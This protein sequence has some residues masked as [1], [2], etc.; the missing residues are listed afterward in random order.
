MNVPSRVII[1][2]C[3]IFIFTAQVPSAQQS[4][5]ANVQVEAQRLEQ[6]KP[7]EREV[8]AG[9]THAYT[10]ALEAGQ[11][12]GAAVNQRGIDV[13]VRVFAPDGSKIAE[14][15]SPNGTQGD[16]PIALEARTAGTY[17]IEVSPFVQGAQPG[18]YEIRINE[19]LS[20]DAYAKRLAENK[21]K[22]RAV[23]A[24]LKENAIPL[25]TV[26]A[27][28]GF[29][30]LQPLKRIFKDVRFVGLGEETHGTREFFQFKHRMLEFLVKEM[31]FRVFAIEASYAACQNIND[32]VM[33]RTDDGAKA[34]DSQGFWTWN[35]EEVRAMMDWMREYNRGVPANRKVKFVG[36]DIQV[37]DTGKAKLLE[38]LKRV[39]PER[40]VAVEEFFK[41]NLS[42]LNSALATPDEQREA[43]AKLKEL[44][45]K[46]NDLFVFLEIS[47]ANLAAKS[48]PAEYEQMREYA[49]VLA[50]YLD[51]YSR[52]G[53]NDG[54]VLRD[55]YMAD[56]FRRIVEREPAGTR[57]VLWAH[58]GHIRTGDS[59]G[60]YP[61]FG[62]HLRR[63]YD[64]EYY[65]LGFSF[66]Q[67]S[68]QAREARPKDPTKRMLMSFTA[69]PAPADSIDWYLAQ[70]GAKIFIVDFRTPHK[71]AGLGEW[72]AAPHPMRSVGAIY[73]PGP[74]QSYFLPHTLDKEFDG[75]FFLDTTT[76]A[77]PNSSV[78]NVAQTQ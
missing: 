50:Q 61:T 23:I 18:R 74:D 12:L 11:F 33:G 68:F 28:N 43:T 30:D 41:V 9:E 48:S 4:S 47:G 62:Y 24:W 58:N 40:V 5:S 7:V 34:L 20:A 15:D 65:A 25:K 21:L 38:Y 26:E 53:S 54:T 51:S 55:L 19:I 37:N 76:R 14:I 16:E 78:K 46:Y 3:G 59:A 73:A 56:N 17:R 42:E 22:Q 2:L 64:K 10:I 71:N 32:Y 27:G 60:T 52:V 6:R 13:I 72:L 31:G 29:G 67:G 77:R 57:F 49:R 1:L 8:K 36:F 63:F 35:T 44:Q 70:T 45:I 66:N 39:A 69:D 75:L